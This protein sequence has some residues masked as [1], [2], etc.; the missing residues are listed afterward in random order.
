MRD[1]MREAGSWQPRRRVGRILS[2]VFRAK[3]A[4]TVTAMYHVAGDMPGACRPR[5]AAILEEAEPNT[6][7]YLDFP[8]SHLKR[9]RMNN[10][11]ER[12]NRE[13]KRR[14]MVVQVFPSLPSLVRL[15][16]AVMCER[17]EVWQKSRYFSEA[18][19]SELYDEKRARGIEGPVDWAQLE[20]DAGKMIES[21]LEIADRVEAA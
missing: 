15:A 16:G 14:S 21:S 10:V 9:L 6:L 12:T 7:A 3:D 5:A 8:P 2:P 1:C 18:K 11:Q 20:I 19:M 13:I 4:A 17:D